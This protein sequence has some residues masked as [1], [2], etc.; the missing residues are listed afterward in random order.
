MCGSFVTTLG[1]LYASKAYHK[2]DF[3][4]IGSWGLQLAFPCLQFLLGTK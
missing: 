2:L 4:N 1:H 3:R